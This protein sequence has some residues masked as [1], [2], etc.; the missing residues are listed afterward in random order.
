MQQNIEDG[1]TFFNHAFNGKYLHDLSESED[2]FSS[3][4]EYISPLASQQVFSDE[5]PEEMTAR[6]LR[7][8][9]H[10]VI[11]HYSMLARDCMY[12]V[13]GLRKN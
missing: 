8:I 12:I 10:V 5:R 3:D 6:N 13:Q 2:N 4:K 1:N 11:T 7:K 9:F